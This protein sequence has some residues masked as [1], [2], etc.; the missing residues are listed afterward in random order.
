LK[1][2]Q[3]GSF[4]LA[5]G[6]CVRD[7]DI[8]RKIMF[9]DRY[10]N[11]VSTSSTQAFDAYA[12]GI[13]SMLA[14][15]DGVEAAFELAIQEDP[16]FLP[17][18]IGLARE[19]QMRGESERVKKILEQA[20]ILDNNLSSFEKSQIGTLSLLLTGKIPAAI[21]S[22]HEHLRHYPRDA[23][24]A[25]TC[26][27]VFGLIG[28]SGQPGREAEQLAFTTSLAPHFGDDWWFLGQHAFAQLEVGQLAKA[29]TSIEQS[30]ATN[31]NSA[32]NAHI[33]AHLYYENG[34][35]NAGMKYLESWRRGFPR[36]ALMHCH[37]AWH[38]ALWALEQGDEEKMWRIFDQDIFPT[39]TGLGPSLN[40][41][42]DAAALLFRAQL[43][44]VD[45]PEGRWLAVSEFALGH[46]PKPGMA[47][48]DVH[49]AVAHAFAGNS[50]A[51]ARLI[52]EARGPAGD[53]VKL[54][55]QAF[56]AIAKAQW[57]EATAY[58][59][60]ILVD[61][62][63][64]GGSRAQRD[65]LQFAFILCLLKQGHRDQARLFLSIHRPSVPVT[66]VKDLPS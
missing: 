53:L 62:A 55:A 23:I 16:S 19:W 8:K 52:T 40:V 43:A 28:F 54:C 14:G 25:Q 63:R 2:P 29:E 30:L 34:E 60:D 56:A 44:G 4:Y 3:L 13:D 61:H 65:L 36:G 27:G 7:I 31:P 47:F 45:I 5:I 1:T 59:A 46:F 58:L 64:I 10:D 15:N 24:V 9:K 22:I 50:D 6:Y 21:K 12:A 66:A 20:P 38:I 35:S 18:H 33:R 57:R 48:A 39:H 32:H 42:T 11:P 41:L 26:M 37:I 51:I 49:G 17:A